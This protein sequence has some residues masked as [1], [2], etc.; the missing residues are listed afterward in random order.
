MKLKSSIR[1][2]EKVGLSDFQCGLVSDSLSISETVHLLEFQIGPKRQKHP[3]SS[4]LV[5]DARRQRIMTRRL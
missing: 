1:M 2:K 5:I 3:V 4:S